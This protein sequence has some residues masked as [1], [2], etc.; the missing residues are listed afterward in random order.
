MNLSNYQQGRIAR[1]FV[2]GGCRI[3][4]N[5]DQCVI[6]PQVEI[7]EGSE[8]TGCVVFNGTVIGGRC[9]I[10]NT[11][12]DKNVRI[13]DGCV[14]GYDAEQDRR[15]FIRTEEGIVVIPKEMQVERTG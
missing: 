10:R 8:L 14:I 7:G 4:G 15:Q 2:S 9:R 11:I 13:P 3:E 5:L 12:I 1:S 6:S